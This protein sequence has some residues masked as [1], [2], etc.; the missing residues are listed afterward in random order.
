MSAL[1]LW[2]VRVKVKESL[3]N[4]F[5]ADLFVCLKYKM[6]SNRV[7]FCCSMFLDLTNLRTFGEY[8]VIMTN[9]NN[10]QKYENKTPVF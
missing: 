6:L 10:G 3:G 4:Y 1:T 8:N 9:S 2:Q 7:N 5:L